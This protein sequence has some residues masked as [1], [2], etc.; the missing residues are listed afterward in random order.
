LFKLCLYIVDIGKTLQFDIC[1]DFEFSSFQALVQTEF[2]TPP[3][4]QHFFYEGDLLHYT[5][6]ST[7]KSL[8]LKNESVLILTHNPLDNKTSQG[9]IIFS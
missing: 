6:S 5:P 7:L 1:D 9:T 2:S 8:K 3:N 4:D